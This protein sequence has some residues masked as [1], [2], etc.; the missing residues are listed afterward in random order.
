[1]YNFQNHT[2]MKTNTHNTKQF[3]LNEIEQNATA[4]LAIRKKSKE[5]LQGAATLVHC[6]EIKFDVDNGDA[7]SVSWYMD[8]EDNHDMYITSVIIDN[9]QLNEINLWSPYTEVELTADYEEFVGRATS[10]EI[11]DLTECI[12]QQISIS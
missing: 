11:D 2:I 3:L 9:G 6:K 12:L 8:D 5:L 10:D 1:M 7:P 4:K